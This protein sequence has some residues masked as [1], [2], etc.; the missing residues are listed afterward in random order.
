MKADL[1]ILGICIF[2]LSCSNEIKNR[3]L[4][5]V[6]SW[7]PSGMSWIVFLVTSRN[8]YNLKSFL[9]VLIQTLMSINV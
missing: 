1:I 4:K 9:P 2:L 5:I 3:K 6:I 8:Q 7:K